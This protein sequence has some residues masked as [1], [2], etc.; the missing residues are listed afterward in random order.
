MKKL[1]LTLAVVTLSVL[2][3]Y[4]QGRVL[5]NNLSSG[6]PI[7]VTTVP[8]FAAPGQGA[9][10]AF[11]GSAYSIQLLWAPQA[12]YASQA[13][14]LAAVIGSSPGFAFF[15]TTGGSPTSDG[16]GLFDAGAVPSPVGT[17][18][19]A[20]AYTMQALAWFNNGVNA[21][22]NAAFAALANTGASAFF[23]ITA[24]AAP[25]P[26]NHTLFPSFTVSAIPEPATMAL[27]GLGS[28][29]LMFFRRRK[30]Q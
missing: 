19:P 1:L 28:A 14:F 4:G 8:A 11:V 2:A 12:V 10:G 20:G 29:G 26:G 17:T 7:S 16:A 6:N 13:A 3:T 9:P 5:F 30:Q 15:G 27:L 25:T 24:T 22:Y 21:T 18:M 23:N